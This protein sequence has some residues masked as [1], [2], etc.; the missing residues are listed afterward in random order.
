MTFEQ[1]RD[2]ADR[3]TRSLRL[4]ISAAGVFLIASVV[5]VSAAPASLLGEAAGAGGSVIT[6]AATPTPS[7]PSAAPPATPPAPVG[8]PTVPQVP[9]DQT[10]V[11]A[12]TGVT[13]TSS[14]PSHLAP[15][16]SGDATKVSSPGG[17]LP[18]TGS[19]ISAA[20]GSAGRI[21]ST[22]AGAAQRPAGSVRNDVGAGADG[23]SGPGAREGTS[24]VHARSVESAETVRPRWFAYVWPAIALGRT[25]KVLATLLARWEGATSLPASNA[26]RLLSQLTGGIGVKGASMFSERPATPNAPLATSPVAPAPAS[27]GMSLFLTMITSLLT[28]GALMALARLVVGEEFFSFLRWP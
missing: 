3:P 16:P 21:T 11:K 9:V 20:K 17:D 5:G 27:G 15:T 18:S 1:T 6:S 24:G 7:L 8:V 2:S 10:P 19:T 4:G 25:G 28:L 14:P 23:R 26:A 13:P 22:S 12:P